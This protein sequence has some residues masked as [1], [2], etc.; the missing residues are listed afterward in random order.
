MDTEAMNLV[1]DFCGN[2][3]PQFIFVVNC[4]CVSSNS[5]KSYFAAMERQKN[6]KWPQ[7][8]DFVSSG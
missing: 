1:G 7:I 5:H 8:L 2:V 4:G 6:N 3:Y